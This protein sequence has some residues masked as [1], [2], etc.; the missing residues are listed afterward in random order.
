LRKLNKFAA[1][2]VLSSCSP[3]FLR[4]N[5]IPSFLESG[6]FTMAGMFTYRSSSGAGGYSFILKCGG[7]E[8]DFIIT[9]AIG[10]TL[11]NAGLE[12]LQGLLMAILSGAPPS[13][14][15]KIKRSDGETVYYFSDNQ[16]YIK[17]ITIKDK[18]GVPEEIE[19]LYKKA[20]ADIVIMD[21]TY[22][23][24]KPGKPEE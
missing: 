15:K 7:E 16:Y 13:F 3:A 18:N 11:G 2:L 22:S 21:I 4:I 6:N 23:A 9:D 19:I 12:D 20:R 24:R 14:T 10:K 17:K 5:D 1:A 8:A